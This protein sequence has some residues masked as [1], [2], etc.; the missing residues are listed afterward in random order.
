MTGRRALALGTGI[1]L[2]ALTAATFA[3]LDLP[4]LDAQALAAR[5]RAAGALGPAA[6]FALL[7]FQCVVAPI[8]SEPLMLAAG[9]V[10]GP[11]LG[12]SIAWLGVVVGAAACFGLAQCF[13]RSLAQRFVRSRHLDAFDAY[14][15]QRGIGFTFAW[16]LV[17]RLLAFSSFDVVSYGCGLTRFPFRWFLLATALG[18]VPKAFAFPYAGASVAVRPAWLDAALLAGTFGFMLL[19]PWLALRRSRR[20]RA[21]Q[22]Q[23]TEA[24]G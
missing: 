2:T 4:A 24:A 11:A 18:V 1:G 13:G 3:W 16:V 22:R 23:R 19:V 14:A 12:F 9:F 20:A 15:A 21:F 6:L 10:Y 8:P 5:V 7:V 17:I